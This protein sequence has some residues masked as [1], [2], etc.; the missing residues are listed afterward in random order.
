VRLR[1]TGVNHR[2]G[3]DLILNA[4]EL[5]GE[6]AGLSDDFVRFLF[7]MA[8]KFPFTWA[9]FNGIISHLT[10]KYSSNVDDK[11]IVAITASSVCASLYPR[12]AADFEDLA[13]SFFGSENQPNQWICF[14]F[15]ALRIEPTHYTIRTFEYDSNHWHLK[16]WVVEGSGDGA[17]WTEID[18]RENNGD[19]NDAWAVK[20]FAVSRS[21]SFGRIRLCQTGPNHRGNHYLFVGAFE[22]FGAVAGLQ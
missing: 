4:F 16:S 1:Q 2:G 21:G 22:L 13:T 11:G 9:P 18:R 10:A 6:V 7:P 3:N 5:F 20:T 14:D 12:C 8:P 17:S 19:L 15:K